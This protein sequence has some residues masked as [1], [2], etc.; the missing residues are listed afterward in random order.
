MGP[1][2]RLWSPPYVWAS[3]FL[4]VNWGQWVSYSLESGGFGAVAKRL[5]QVLASPKRTWV[6]QGGG[7]PG[8]RPCSRSAPRSQA[9]RHL[10]AGALWVYLG[11]SGSWPGRGLASARRHP[12]PSRTEISSEPQL[13]TQRC[14]R[15]GQ[16]TSF[17]GHTWPLCQGL[18]CSRALFHLGVLLC[19]PLT[20][21]PPGASPPGSL[22]G[23]PETAP[24]GGGGPS[25]IPWL[26]GWPPQHGP[27]PGMEGSRP[28]GARKPERA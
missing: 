13:P 17:C 21:T 8:R 27:G 20:P 18:L 24:Q 4:S 7:R 22:Q 10:G 12:L 11:T 15:R 1:R 19:L 23:G 26:P 14:P 6:R 25:P 3:V 16:L 5:A 2:W 9:G 28:H